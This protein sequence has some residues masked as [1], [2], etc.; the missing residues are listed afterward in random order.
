MY[1]FNHISVKQRQL[2]DRQVDSGSWIVQLCEHNS[3]LNSHSGWHLTSSHVWSN[4]TVRYKHP[5]KSFDKST[6]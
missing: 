2:P 3:G 5:L 6:V 4:V 1:T